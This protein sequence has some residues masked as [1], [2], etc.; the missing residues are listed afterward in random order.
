[1]TLWHHEHERQ[2]LTDLRDRVFAVGRAA[3][4][5]TR[6]R[7]VHEIAP[8]QFGLY[9]STDYA[10]AIRELVNLGCIDRPNAVAIKDREPLRFID[11]PQT[12]LLD[13]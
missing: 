10:K 4:T 3:G 8:Q 6:E 9:T 2:R 1:M 13:A 5:A 12:S 7:L 11:P